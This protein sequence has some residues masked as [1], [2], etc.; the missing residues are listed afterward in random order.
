M[1]R[2][3]H[4]GKRAE[5]R[6]RTRERILAATMLVHDEKGIAPATLAEIA[7]RAGVSQ[8][9]LSRH[10]PTYGEL[11][12]ACGGHVWQD[13]RPPVAE[14]AAAVFV[15]LNGRRDRLR[16]LVEEL[17]SFYA[18]GERRLDLAWRDRN[19]MPQID[20]FLLAVESGV[21]ALV[22]EALAP[23]ERSPFALR[24]ASALTSFRVWQSIRRQGFDQADV[25]DVL[26]RTLVCGLQAAAKR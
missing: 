8:A 17:D 23:D 9:T 25:R 7:A 21:D 2:K 14:T 19:L 10:F 24:V 5:D 13:M 26:F 18:R 6:E 4:M 3:Y 12:Q 1:T 22:N 15:G 20:G 11:V 16:R